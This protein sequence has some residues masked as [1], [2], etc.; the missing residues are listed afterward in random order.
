MRTLLVEDNRRL[1]LSLKTSL[2]EEGYAV[3]T[4]FDGME[5]LD[6]AGYTPYD[7]IIL[8]V[9]LPGMNGLEVCRTLRISAIMCSGLFSRKRRRKKSLVEQ[10]VQA[11][12]QPR[13]SSSGKWRQR[14]TSG[15]R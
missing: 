13:P 14:R 15:K 7:V 6:L 11:K 5:G 8:D 2:I 3:D 1:N 12:G 9:M 10:K 4:A